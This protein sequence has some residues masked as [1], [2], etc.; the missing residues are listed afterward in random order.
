LKTLQSVQKYEDL[1]AVKLYLADWG[2]NTQKEREL[3]EENPQIQVIS[4]DR[5]S[6]IS[7]QLSES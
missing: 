6:A 2:Y 5:L 1:A 7:H 3:A 4:L